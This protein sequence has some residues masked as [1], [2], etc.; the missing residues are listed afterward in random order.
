[1]DGAASCSVLVSAWVSRFVADLDGWY[2][3][4]QTEVS[5]QEAL[6]ILDRVLGDEVVRV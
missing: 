3:F 6:H 5:A 2:G 1:V 4:D